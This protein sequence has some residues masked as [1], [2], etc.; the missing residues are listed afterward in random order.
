LSGPL[1]SAPQPDAVPQRRPFLPLIVAL[2]VGVG[3]GFGW[4]YWTAWRAAAREAPAAARATVPNS[5]SSTVPSPA[6]TPQRVEEPRVLGEGTTAPAARS[7]RR[8]PADAPRAP[9]APASAPAKPAPAQ[10]GSERRAAQMA[11]QASRPSSATTRPSG[12]GRVPSRAPAATTGSLVVDSRPLG[13]QVS[14]DGQVMGTTPLTLPDVQPG[15]HRIVLEIPGF[16]RWITMVQVTAGS[17]MRV[18]A[19]LEQ[20]PQP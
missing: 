7:S 19:S 5:P 8:P 10:A 18:A 9:A 14:V 17:R 2:L 16:N 20:V 6:T 11:R 1:W 12:D 4:G 13:A 15:A 3:G